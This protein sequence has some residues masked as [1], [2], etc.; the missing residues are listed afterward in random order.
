MKEE[1]TMRLLPTVLALCTVFPMVA[2]AQ[3]ATEATPAPAAAP[4][5]APPVLPATAPAPAAEAAAPA[6][7]PAAPPP[8]A[9]GWE[10]LVDAYYLYNFTGDP[11]TQG[12]ARSPVRH[13]GE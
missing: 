6:P 10:A 2:N 4:V 3:S 12:P 5:Q 11:K 1:K 13:H 9:F 7:A 8:I